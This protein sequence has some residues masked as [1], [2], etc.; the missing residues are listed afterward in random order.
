MMRQNRIDDLANHY[1]LKGKIYR[2][3]ALSPQK[4]YGVAY[5]GIAA[6]VYSMFPTFA[7]TFGHTLTTAGITASVLGGMYN[8]QEKDYV[9]SIEFVKDE[10][11]PYN[12]KLKMNVSTGPLMTSRD[13]F[14]DA[15]KCQG[16]FSLDND[17]L[18][19]ADVDN[20]VLLVQSYFDG[21]TGKF[22]EDAN[23][24]LV[25]PADGWRDESMLEWVLS[26]KSPQSN[27]SD[28]QSLDALFNDVML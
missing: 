7:M 3:K 26:I 16:L 8:L 9:N 14:V 15:N 28:K 24:A 13:I 27:F 10:G 19:E 6:S 12:G 2:R 5:F 4:L 11:S 25:L 21:N 20:N 1:W 18:G 17:D 22:L 23:E